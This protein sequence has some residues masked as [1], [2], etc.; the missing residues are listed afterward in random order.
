MLHGHLLTAQLAD[1]AWPCP[2]GS[3]PVPHIPALLGYQITYHLLHHDPIRSPCQHLLSPVLCSWHP[4]HLQWCQQ[5]QRHHHQLRPC[6][7]STFILLN[8][9]ELEQAGVPCRSCMANHTETYNLKWLCAMILHLQMAARLFAD[10]CVIYRSIQSIKEQVLLQHDLDALHLWGQCLGMRFNVKKCNIINLGKKLF[11]YFYRLNNVVSHPKYL[12]VILTEDLS[13]S[14]HAHI[15][16]CGQCAPA[17][18]L[19]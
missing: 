16:Y 3:C 13:W 7:L 17:P 14:P 11:Q 5:C 8:H 19:H 15:G 6:P 18:G 2:H 4:W 12:S 9:L 1:C 10:D